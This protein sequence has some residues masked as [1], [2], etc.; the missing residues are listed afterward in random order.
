MDSI[1]KDRFSLS[2]NL[3]T[4]FSAQPIR[5]NFKGVVTFVRLLRKVL[6]VVTKRR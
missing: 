5:P 4:G 6:T 3:L 2:V 1:F